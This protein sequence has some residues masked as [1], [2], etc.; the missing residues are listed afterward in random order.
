MTAEEIKLIMR[1]L[2]CL[3]KELIKYGDVPAPGWTML[4]IDA[5]KEKFNY[6]Y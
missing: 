2:R 4:K 6:E 5:L 3:E 1:A